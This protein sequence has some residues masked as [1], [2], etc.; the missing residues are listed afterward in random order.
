MRAE[1]LSGFLQIDSSWYS[2]PTS[3]G[4][5]QIAVEEKLVCSE[6]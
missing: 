6:S 1:S 3:Y 2:F 4:L 5:F